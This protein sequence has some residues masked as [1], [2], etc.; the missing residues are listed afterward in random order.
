MTRISA[1]L[2][3]V[4]ALVAATPE[5]AAA[6]TRTSDH[7]ANEW[8]NAKR[9]ELQKQRDA[10]D[11]QIDALDTSVPSDVEQT[12][13]AP[14][15]AP[16]PA[17]RVVAAAPAAKKD[18]APPVDPGA[19]PGNDEDLGKFAGLKFGV[20][21]SF[22]LD[23]GDND[24]VTEASLVN[25][26]VRVDDED[27]GRAR[28]MLESHYFFTPDWQWTGLQKGVW[29]VGPFVSLQPG[30]DNIIEAIGMGLMFGFRRSSG[31]ESFNLGFGMI[32]DPN[33]RVLGDG[34]FADRPLP[35]GETEVRFKEEMQRGF[36]ILSSFSF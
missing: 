31:K 33:T 11:Q 20:G 4:L 8:R 21:I 1:I 18:V 19:P 35:N 15:P 28:I 25:G 23:S 16:A 10:L 2:V 29:G 26:V 30:T 14:I 3:S 12:M 36:L 27:N 24:R 34:V 5:R 7:I 6:Q 32:A 13:A 22:T 17:A 9:A